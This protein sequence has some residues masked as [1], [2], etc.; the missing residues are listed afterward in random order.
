MK[1]KKQSNK[2]EI[3]PPAVL[4]LEQPLICSGKR[5][6]TKPKSYV[7]GHKDFPKY[8]YG[9]T[10]LQTDSK[11]RPVPKKFEVGSINLQTA[12]IMNDMY[13]IA[14]DNLDTGDLFPMTEE[15]LDLY[16]MG[17]IMTQYSHNKGLQ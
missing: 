1:L 7:V 13:A 15:D 8:Q 14:A 3:K 17:V 10:H 9:H 4:L 5:T 6:R 16:I 12:G 11:M 2:K